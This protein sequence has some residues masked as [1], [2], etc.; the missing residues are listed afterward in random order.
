MDEVEDSW[1]LNIIQRGYGL[2]FKVCP[3]KKQCL[4]AYVNELIA[5]AILPVLRQVWGERVYSSLF[6]VAK[7]SGGFRLVLDITVL[8]SFMKYPPFKMESLETIISVVE[9]KE[10]GWL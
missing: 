4:Q 6:F 1:I 10:V 3:K 9:K 7:S 2:E 8:N 5:Q